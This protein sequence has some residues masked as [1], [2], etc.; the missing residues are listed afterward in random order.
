MQRIQC[1]VCLSQSLQVE[2]SM[3]NYP[4]T[5][6]A[7]N[8]Q[9]KADQLIS[10]TLISCSN[11]NCLQLQNL[12]DP[13]VLYEMYH[14]NS[15]S[16]VWIKHHKL[17]ADFIYEGLSSIDTKYIIEIGGSS[18]VIAEQLSLKS[19]VRY[20]IFDLCDH[21]PK[22]PNVTFQKGNCETHD[23]PSESAIVMS[24]VFEHLYEPHKFI[25]NMSRNNIQNIFLSIPNMTLQMANK[26]HPV[27]YQ[28][29]TYLCELND[30][31]Y[32]CSN[33]GYKLV[34]S[35][36]YDIHAILLHFQKT[37]E[38]FDV[39]LTRPRDVVTNIVAVYNEKQ[40]IARG[41]CLDAPY[42]VIPACFSGLLIYYN[43]QD[44]YKA[45]CLGFLDNDTTKTAKRIYGTSLTV[46]RME[47][48]KEYIGPLHIVI[49][50]GAY[51][52]EIVTQLKSYKDDIKFHF[53]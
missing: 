37:D 21:D 43:I 6:L 25:Q 45:N 48:V 33:Y 22:I 17:L 19:D 27:I 36:F 9:E 24:H 29:H 2:Y 4:I 18:G 14:N 47:K 7:E 13:A 1:A 44:R 30:V 5:F 23:F 16:P 40:S 20:S 34:K 8:T 49:H 38:P 12:V 3:E 46:Y 10:H 51:V 28:E 52:D 41:L 15:K 32:I 42:F 35:F 53:V 50:R 39:A 31:E 26:I 11:C